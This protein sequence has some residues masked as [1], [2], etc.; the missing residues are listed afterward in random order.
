MIH[1]IALNPSI[2]YLMSASSID[3][4]KTN[5]S[6][7]EKIRIGGK[8]INVAIVLNNLG[9]DTTLHGFLGGFTGEHIREN[10]KEYPRINDKFINSN[11]LTRINVK[12]KTD[13]ETELNG[14]GEIIDS[15]YIEQLEREI[16]TFTENDIVVMSGSISR[17]MNYSWYTKIA[18]YLHSKKIDFIVDIGSH[19]LINIL[20]YHPLLI[21]P[22]IDEFLQITNVS[23]DYESILIA[24]KEMLKLGVKNIIISC[25]KD[26]SIYISNQELF[27]ATVPEGKLIDSVGA[28]DSMVAGFIAGIVKGESEKETYLL[29][30]ASGTATAFSEALATS[31][32]IS[33]L[34][35][36]IKIERI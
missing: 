2:D 33:T 30:S 9:I 17:G 4:G 19:E 6:N 29:A 34:M 12:I 26:G 20:E 3:L 31:D 1:I 36:K 25:G 22:N 8:G 10:L 11:V 18:K 21:K 28:G 5:R 13:I 16:K 14:S 35:N 32:E 23:D 27:K 24:G 7:F 15:R